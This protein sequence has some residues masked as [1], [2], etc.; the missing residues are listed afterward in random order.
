MPAILDAATDRMDL[1]AHAELGRALGRL[2]L[3]ERVRILSICGVGFLVAFAPL[4]D[5]DLEPVA[6]L[7]GFSLPPA[8]VYRLRSTLPRARFASIARPLSRPDDLPASLAD[9]GF[10]PRREVLLDGTPADP[11]G[12]APHGP[13]SAAILEDL[14][15]RIVLRVEAP[16]AGYLVLS[17]AFAPGWRA[18]VDGMAAPILRANGLFRAV[19]LDPGSHEVVMLYRPRGVLL[20]LAVSLCAALIAAGWWWRAGAR[21]S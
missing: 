4:D 18:R 17:D 2:R 9:A 15:E 1:A 19:R 5:P 21:A 11:D 6:T 7:E 10:D 20:G 3:P 14:P 12:A 16:A 13:G 8:R